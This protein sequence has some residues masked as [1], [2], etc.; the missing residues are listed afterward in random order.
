MRCAENYTKFWY[1]NFKETN[2]WEAL[3]TN[4]RVILKG[5]LKKPLERLTVHCMNLD[6]YTKN[7][8]VPLNMGI[9]IPTP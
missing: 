4:W 6:E 1:E 8:W 9:N 7:L 5:I 3:N 2:H